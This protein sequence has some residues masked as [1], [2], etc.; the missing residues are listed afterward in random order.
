M[1]SGKKGKQIKRVKGSKVSKK[2]HFDSHA[3]IQSA[4]ETV[5]EL[6]FRRR[7]PV[8]APSAPV[9]VSGRIGKIAF[10]SAHF[11][12]AISYVVSQ[13][14]PSGATDVNT[15]LFLYNPANVSDLL[16]R[17]IT[18]LLPPP[19]VEGRDFI[20][21]RRSWRLPPQDRVGL[22]KREGTIFRVFFEMDIEPIDCQ[23]IIHFGTSVGFQGT[24]YPRSRPSERLVL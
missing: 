16:L 21:G 24:V 18:S 20:P 10:K 1:N 2:V 12:K 4:D 15:F 17:I 11:R 19:Q 22:P 5:E 7:L 13:S 8:C 3:K 9:S 23:F 6:R 14:G